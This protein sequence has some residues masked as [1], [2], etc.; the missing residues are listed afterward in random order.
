MDTKSLI[1]IMKNKLFLSSFAFLSMNNNIMQKKSMHFLND[2]LNPQSIA[3]LGANNQYTTFGTFLLMNIISNG[4]KRNIYPIHLKLD[5]VLGRKAYKNIADVPEV[6]DLVI[7]VLPPKIVPQV[8]RE[9][10]EKG[11]KNMVV[12]SGGFREVTGYKE[13][14]LT[15]EI[16]EIAK[17]Y[18]MRFTGPN[19]FGFY[20][21]W[22]DPAN[23]Q[24]FNMMVFAKQRKPGKFS[25]ASQSG[26]M[27][28][29]IFGD[30]E[31]HDVDI[32]KTISVGNEANMDLVDFLEYFKEDENTNAIGL[33]IEEI[34]RGQKFI[35][36]AK[37]ITPKKPIVAIYAGGSGAA[38]RAIGS[39]T[40]SMAG[41]S[42]IFDAMVK[43]TGIIKTPYVQEFL[44]LAGILSKDEVIY[45]KGNRLGIITNSGGPGAMI[46]N[47]AERKGLIV[48]EL[49]SKLQDKFGKMM[50]HTASYKNPIDLTFD[51]N[52][53]NLYVNIPKTLM[54]SGE[55]DAIII[56][57]IF[58]F[59]ERLS[60][61]DESSEVGKYIEM[62]EQMNENDLNNMD[63]LF[64]E[65][66]MKVS[67]KH[68]IP[69]FYINPESYANEW[70]NTIR[71]YGANVFKLWDRPVNA[72]AKLCEYAEYRRTHS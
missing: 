41:N 44:D 26:T 19:C 15:E 64:I 70:S 32:G 63:K 11:V 71:G 27:T 18:G 62:P 37:E 30:V 66:I 56:Y 45:P 6:P 53:F 34:K 61:I 21:A 43:E 48:P 57:G 47:N 13:N 60:F 38:N 55:V 7:I 50:A 22:I 28:S 42:K 14:N 68:S 31:N 20:N 46:A 4:Y 52:I 5:K 59:K 3:I 36:V 51:M 65:P 16:C 35:E 10:G 24:I 29:H 39:H 54:R 2:F 40:G 17:N 33:Y 8:F 67:K 72:L 23:G 12:I 58:G 9:C 69:I 1:N 25:L 49:S